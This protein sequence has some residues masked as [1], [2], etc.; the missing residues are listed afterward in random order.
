Q[1]AMKFLALTTAALM[2]TAV[3]AATPLPEAEVNAQPLSLHKNDHFPFAITHIGQESQDGLSNQAPVQKR[4]TAHLAKRGQLGGQSMM[5]SH[6]NA[7]WKV[8]DYNT[9]GKPL[10]DV[11]V[12]ALKTS[13]TYGA[14]TF[15][16]DADSHVFVEWN[17]KGLPALAEWAVRQMTQSVIDAQRQF[18]FQAAEFSWTT[19][20][21]WHDN[22]FRGDPVGTM[23]IRRV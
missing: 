13:N 17:M 20:S 3:V 9:F 16:V 22:F 18:Q 10:I 15:H 14:R 6:G 12:K 1:F 19:S 8:L 21:Y 11:M 7:K 5:T 23:T 4:D 2:A